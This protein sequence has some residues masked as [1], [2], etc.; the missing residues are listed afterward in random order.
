MKAAASNT[1]R[2]NTNAAS[3]K[4][5]LDLNSAVARY[6]STHSANSLPRKETTPVYGQ[7]TEFDARL[8]ARLDREEHR[9]RERIAARAQVTEYENV[10]GNHVIRSG[11]ICRENNAKMAELMEVDSMYF[12]RG[13]GDRGIEFKFD[14]KSKGDSV[15]EE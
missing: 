6:M 7:G 13:C 5:P 10:L 11:D 1:E 14:P 8:S 3:S 2:I 4:K 9:H 12:I 15:A